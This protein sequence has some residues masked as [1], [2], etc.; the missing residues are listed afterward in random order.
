MKKKWIILFMLVPLLFS[1]CD[2]SSEV[3]DAD[4]E[5][6][7]VY[8]DYSS[9]DILKSSI[10]EIL[11]FDTEFIEVDEK[12]NAFV[13]TGKKEGS[14]T[15]L[16]KDGKGKKK[17][18]LV[19]IRLVLNINR[20]SFDDYSADIVCSDPKIH[21]E[22]MVDLENYIFQCR[23][24]GKTPSTILLK[25]TKKFELKRHSGDN[26]QVLEGTYSYD[27]SNLFLAINS[28]QKMTCMFSV[29][30]ELPMSWD[31]TLIHDLTESYKIKYP[32][33]VDKVKI[34]YSISTGKILLGDS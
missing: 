6:I 2:G 8:M 22:I 5:S 33:N 15:L 30:E 25:P 29:V 32:D 9:L 23:K 14:T 1:N 26:V 19:S 7:K 28:G 13:I 17:M 18:I 4:K 34:I 31:A 20:W 21:D 16:C 3:P 24:S 27:L 10:S 11:E 12:A